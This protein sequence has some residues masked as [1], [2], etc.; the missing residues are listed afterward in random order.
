MKKVSLL[1]LSLFIATS[2]IEAASGNGTRKASGGNQKG[3][4]ISSKT[5][6][7]SAKA[8]LDKAKS[9]LSTE[10][11]TKESNTQDETS[12]KKINKKPEV[13]DR[14]VCDSEYTRCMN[15]VCVN[16]TLGKCV[17]YE[18]KTTNSTST[19]FLEFDGVKVRQGFEALEFAKKQCLSVLDKCGDNRRSVTEKYRNSVQKDCLMISKNEILK[20]KGVSGDLIELKQCVRDACTVKTLEGY[21]NFTF[22]EYSLCFNEAY[23][24]F[25]MDAYC[26]KIIAKSASPLGLKQLFLDEMA[27]GREKSCKT[28]DGTLSNDRKKC[29]VNIKYGTSKE[30]IK[31]SK[32]FAIGEYVECSASNFGTKQ[33]AT[34]EKRQKD[35]NSILSVTATAFNTAGAVLGMVGSSD[36]IGGLVSNGID[37][38]EAGANLG[39]DIKDYKDGKLNAQQ[40][41]SSVISN[42]LS[43]SMSSV[44]LAKSARA[45]SGTL[46]NTQATNDSLKAAGLSTENI[47]Q[48]SDGS[49][50]QLSD[51]ALKAK[52]AAKILNSVSIGF[53]AGSEVADKVMENRADNMQMAE[54][55]KGIIKHAEVN[56]NT[57][58]GKIA[59]TLTEKGNCFLNGEWF[60]TENELIMLLWKN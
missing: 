44:S 1:I 19:S 26:S 42:G 59:D 48:N 47:V 8:K 11:N 50:T 49:V 22:P 16:D 5:G 43:I 13:L 41:S 12:V 18:D 58:T 6:R 4:R 32:Q 52:K 39:L 14:A 3:K 27:L 2:E 38:V 30:N 55:E 57:G 17:C 9:T 29:Y 21:E 10:K 60:A 33:G 24:K 25:S 53:A 40:L 34:W 23:A 28:L 46:K 15:K 37:I 20:P 45:V 51:A 54:E 56:R 35:L 7:N 31:A 36:P